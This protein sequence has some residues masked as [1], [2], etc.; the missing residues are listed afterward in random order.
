MRDLPP[1]NTLKA[2]EAASKRLNVRR[3][4]D[5]LCITPAAVSKQIK[6]LEEFLGCKLFIRDYRGLQLTDPGRVYLFHVQRSLAELRQATRD[7]SRPK[8]KSLIRL[9]SYS[10]FSV[11]WLVPRIADFYALHPDISVDITTTSRWIE[12]NEDG[13]DAAIR[14]GP[15]GWDD[16][17]YYPLVNNILA[18]V[19]SPHLS[20]LLNSVEDLRNHTLLHAQARIDDWGKWLSLFGPDDIDPYVGQKYESSILAYQAAMQGQGISMGQLELV[21][22]ELE[23]GNLVLPFKQKLDMDKYTYYLVTPK[24]ADH[25]PELDIFCQWLRSYI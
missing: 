10:T 24:S 1:L 25:N 17:N 14:L 16:M 8:Q 21:R 12:F 3:A 2:F 6:S 18:P 4:A 22:S 20:V 13:V 15:G 9:R 7:V 11:Y 23:K 5:D 19:C